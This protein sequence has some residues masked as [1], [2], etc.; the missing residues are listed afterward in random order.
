MDRPD[1][2]RRPD[3]RGLSLPTYTVTRLAA[4]AELRDRGGIAPVAEVE[5]MGQLTGGV[6]HDSPAHPIWLLD[7][8]T[9]RGLGT[10]RRR[11]IDGALNRPSRGAVRLLAFGAAAWAVAVDWCAGRAWPVIGSTSDR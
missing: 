3:R 4:H 5:A 10:P 8:L 2:T 6:A 7:M 9:R 1:P 11:L